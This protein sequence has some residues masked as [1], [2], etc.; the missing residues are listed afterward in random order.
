MNN[1]LWRTAMCAIAATC[2]LNTAVV[3]AEPA[4]APDA[5]AERIAQ[6]TRDFDVPGIAVASVRNGKVQWIETQ[7]KAGEDRPVSRETLFN[8]ASLTKPMFATMVMHLVDEGAVS[9]D[10]SLD[11]HWVDPDIADDPRHEKIT[12]RLALSHQTGLPNWRGNNELAFAFMPGERHE[13]S[14]EG[15]EYLRRAVEMATQQSMPALMAEHVTGPAGMPRTYY[16]WDEAVAESLATGYREDGQAL[17]MTHLQQRGPNAAASTFTNIADVSA[18]AAWVAGGADLRDSVFAEM[19]RPQAVHENPAEQFSIGWRVTTVDGTPVITHDGREDGLRTLLIVNPDTKDGLVIL[20]NSSNGE[21]L[22]R[23]IIS[24]ALPGGDA[25]NAQ[26]DRDIWK[27]ISAQPPQM[28]A[29][30]LGFI[31]RSPSF[32]A[33][34]LYAVDTSLVGP[35]GAGEDDRKQSLEATAAVVRAHHS[36]TLSGEQLA[37][38]L[39][40]LDADDG[41]GVRLVQSFDAEQARAWLESL[42]ALA[43][44]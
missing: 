2:C 12:A 21:L 1:Q 32:T 22:T 8:V 11:R 28:H 43:E 40:L 17:D 34:L 35:A 42:A 23:G 30:L 19:I 7:G 4:A 14:G 39:G 16:G 26:T 13:Y 25:L 15:F 18:F 31:V 27:Y 38:H 6:E 3:N 36:G 24:A 33:K 37:Q 44:T 20:T 41:D 10:A 5:I 9:L 29:G